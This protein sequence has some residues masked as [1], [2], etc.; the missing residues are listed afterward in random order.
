MTPI[1]NACYCANRFLY[2]ITRLTR[3]ASAAIKYAAF[4]AS[5]VLNLNDM[6]E[7]R[8]AYSTNEISVATSWTESTGGFPPQNPKYDSRRKWFLCHKVCSGERI[9]SIATVARR[10]PDSG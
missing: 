10:L 7:C 8:M 3:K 5:V 1:C 2:A 4:S 6:R 9:L